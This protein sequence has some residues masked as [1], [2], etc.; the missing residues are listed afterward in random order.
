MNRK[1]KREK[2]RHDDGVLKQFPDFPEYKAYVKQVLGQTGKRELKTYSEW[3]AWMK[4]GVNLK[5]VKNG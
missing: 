2:A 1:A 3:K 4:A 5:D